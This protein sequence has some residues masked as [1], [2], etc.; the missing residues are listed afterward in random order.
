MN[1]SR[2]SDDYPTGKIYIYSQC[3][4]ITWN[5]SKLQYFVTFSNIW[6]FM[7]KVKKCNFRH[8]LSIFE[9]SPFLLILYFRAQIQKLIFFATFFKNMY[10]NFRAK[11]QKVQFLPFYVNFSNILI[12]TKNLTV[13]K[14]K[15]A[16]FENYFF[17]C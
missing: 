6:I 13:K 11:N 10:L 4:K 1:Y 12:L 15:L 14:T 16:N 7:A 2:R 3:L 9:F 17:E 8:F 5:V